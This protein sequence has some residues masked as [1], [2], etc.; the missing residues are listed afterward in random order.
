MRM[1]KNTRN[2]ALTESISFLFL[3]STINTIMVAMKQN[4]AVR[5]PEP[6]KA[7]IPMHPT[8]AKKIL[9]LVTFIVA[10]IIRNAADATAV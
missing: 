2:T 9:I 7:H 3:H 8:I 5:V 6:K 4:M 10:A 1:Y